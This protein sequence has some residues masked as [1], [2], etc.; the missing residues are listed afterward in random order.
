[1]SE[2]KKLVCTVL[3]VDNVLLVHKLYNIY[4]NKNLIPMYF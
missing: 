3:V 2:A 1:M 4:N